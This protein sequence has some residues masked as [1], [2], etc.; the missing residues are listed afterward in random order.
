MQGNPINAGLG[1]K[2]QAEIDFQSTLPDSLQFARYYN[3]MGIQYGG[4]RWY[5]KWTDTYQRSII[6]NSSVATV[7][8]Q[9]GKSYNFTK[10]GPNWIPDAD[11][12]T[13]LRL[14]S[15]GGWQ[16]VNEQDETE[17]YSSSVLMTVQN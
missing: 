7:Y 3:S 11:V 17:I 5:Q 1:N 4:T 12:T 13:T 10:I 14:L 9:D 15:G 8:R 2:F 6:V 16:Y